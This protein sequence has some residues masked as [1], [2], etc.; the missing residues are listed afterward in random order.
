M[1]NKLSRLLADA[2][3]SLTDHQ[4]TLLVAYVDMLHKW[5]KAYNLTSVRDPNEMLVRHILDS[6]VVA[7]YLQEQRFIDV[8]TGPGL[9][10]IPLAIVLPDAHFT[11]LDSLGKRVRFLRQVQHELKLEN[12]TPVQSRVEAYPSEPPFD[13][14]IS[15]AF[16]S[17]NDMVSWCH[18]LPG[19][20]GRF[21][22]LKGQ[23]PGDE[24]ASLPDNFS[25]ESVEKLRVPQLE[26]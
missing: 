18:H 12:I 9:P 6:I 20:K 21:Y 7:P 5:N 17:L 25:V 23:L 14:V 1:L 13:G 24:I 11:L 22:A 10:G 15:R 2:G 19:E 4:K 3:I 16:A 26:G 8:G